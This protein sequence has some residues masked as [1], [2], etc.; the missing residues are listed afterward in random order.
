MATVSSIQ[1]WGVTKNEVLQAST[2]SPTFSRSASQTSRLRK[3]ITSWGCN[4]IEGLK[5][6]QRKRTSSSWSEL[7]GGTRSSRNE[8][9][10]WTSR[11][12]IRHWLETNSSIHKNDGW[13]RS[14]IHWLAL[15]WTRVRCQKHHAHPSKDRQWCLLSN[16]RIVQEALT[17]RQMAKILPRSKGNQRKARIVRKRLHQPNQSKSLQWSRWQWTG[18]ISVRWLLEEI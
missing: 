8:R 4:L 17:W 14:Q 13:Y 7:W 16:C 10:A 3:Q 6:H 5:Y 18:W 1:P 12:W 2:F 15:E 9:V 11:R